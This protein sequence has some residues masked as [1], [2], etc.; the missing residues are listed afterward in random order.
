MSEALN[1][2][3]DAAFEISER[4]RDILAQ[5]REAFDRGD[6]SEALTLAKK[7]CGVDDEQKS[8]RTDQ[9]VN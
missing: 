8:N 6:V 7:L 9:S 4:R 5:M 1:G 2:I 3:I